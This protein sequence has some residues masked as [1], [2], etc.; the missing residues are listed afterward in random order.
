MHLLDPI[1]VYID[2]KK[3]AQE[4]S[5]RQAFFRLDQDARLAP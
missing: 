1:S 3:I 4:S 5:N 2:K